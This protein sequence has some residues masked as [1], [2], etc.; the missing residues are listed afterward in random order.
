MI[1]IITSMR[2]RSSSIIGIICMSMSVVYYIFWFTGRLL[3]L[4]YMSL[5]QGR[6]VRHHFQTGA[7]LTSSMLVTKFVAGVDCRL[8]W[9]SVVIAEGTTLTTTWSQGREA[10]ATLCQAPQS[11]RSETRRHLRRRAHRTT[12][13]RGGRKRPTPLSWTRPSAWRSSLCLHRGLSATSNLS[14]QPEKRCVLTCTLACVCARVPVCTPR[15]VALFHI[16]FRPAARHAPSRSNR[17]T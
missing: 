3:C 10:S 7:S 13:I 4:L 5:T 17:S 6:V 16:Q 15:L 8:M 11:P 1:S 12:T 14:L 9:H 2:S